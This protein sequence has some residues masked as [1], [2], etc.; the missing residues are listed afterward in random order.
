MSHDKIRICVVGGGATGLSLLWA[1][2]SQKS[3]GDRVEVTLLHDYEELGGHSYTYPLTFEN[4]PGQSWP[5]EL[6]VQFVCPLLYPNL[7]KMLEQPGFE[8]V[9]LDT[10][11]ALKI[12]STF[13]ESMNWGNFAA[14][15]SGPL[16]DQCWTPSAKREAERFTLAVRRSPLEGTFDMTLSDYFK[17][18]SYS[19]HFKHYI[20]TPYLSILNG[21]GGSKMMMEAQFE[22]LFPLFLPDIGGGPLGS[23]T[24]PGTGWE[25]FRNGV[26]TWVDAMAAFGLEHGATIKTG[27]PVLAVWPQ[28]DGTVIVEWKPIDGA[29]QSD[30]FD[31]VILTTNMTVNRTL[32]DNKHNHEFFL[33]YQEPYISEEL[34]PLKGG[35]CYIHTDPNVFPPYMPS[36]RPETVQFTAYNPSGGELPI[37]KTYST[38]VLQN[39]VPGLPQPAYLTMYGEA[40]PDHPPDQVHFS[41]KWLHGHFLGSYFYDSAAQVHNAQNTQNCGIW[42]AGNNTTQD[43]EEGA[44]VSALVIADKMFD[45]WSYPFPLLSEAYGYYLLFRD[46]IMFPDSDAGSSARRR[47]WLN[48]IAPNL[49]I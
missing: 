25:R 24:Q 46:F 41:R 43:S 48:L 38:Y 42:F 30:T 12:A 6:G 28:T 15:Q 3:V 18:H 2:Y 37:A 16:F 5:V 39:M 44:L 45:D 7:H 35:S 27:C 40:E 49:E 23:F 26:K 19:E 4:D 32:L 36:E 31:R 21:Y 34:F 10:Y 33:T 1:L 17:G 20:L 8:N 9:H 29:P 22:D 11:P 47:H 13:S 14:Y